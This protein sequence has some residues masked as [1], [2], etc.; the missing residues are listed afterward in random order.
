MTRIRKKIPKY[1]TDQVKEVLFNYGRRK[2]DEGD[3]YATIKETD[4][5]FYDTDNDYTVMNGC[6]GRKS[7]C[8]PSNMCYSCTVY[9]NKYSLAYQSAIE[10]NCKINEVEQIKRDTKRINHCERR[11][12]TDQN[13]EPRKG[14][15]KQFEK[16]I[17]ESSLKMYCT[18]MR[19]NS[20]K[21]LG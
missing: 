20:K 15:F 19:V 18:E 9:M 16:Y 12:I 11:P 4:R 21:Y 3:E 13:T 8:L 5:L 10:M 7:Y 2:Y 6:K 17:D 1:F 14:K